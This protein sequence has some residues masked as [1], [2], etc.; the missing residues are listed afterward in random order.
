MV[1][2]NL[3]M[4]LDFPPF[5][6]LKSSQSLQFS[7]CKLINLSFISPDPLPIVYL[8]KNSKYLILKKLRI[9]PDAG[10]PYIC[11]LYSVTEAKRVLLPSSFDISFNFSALRLH[12]SLS[13]HSFAK[14]LPAS[15]MY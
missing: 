5:S 8:N 14:V 6:V 1:D 15:K 12:W 11:E 7:V 2:N 10:K 4:Y 13:K 3:I 9:F